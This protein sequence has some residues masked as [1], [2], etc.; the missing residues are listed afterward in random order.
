MRIYFQVLGG[1][2]RCRVFGSPGGLCGALTFDLK[3]WPQIRRILAHPEIQ[4][5]EEEKCS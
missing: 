4:F 1:H 5:I 3:E 2:V